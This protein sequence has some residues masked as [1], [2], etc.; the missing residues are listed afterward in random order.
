MTTEA[1]QWKKTPCR[2]TN[3]N[4]FQTFNQQWAF[5]LKGI[6]FYLA[7]G[8][9]YQMARTIPVTPTLNYLII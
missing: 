3:G 9:P 7:P 1:Y 5:S 4:L 2:L 6:N 8:L